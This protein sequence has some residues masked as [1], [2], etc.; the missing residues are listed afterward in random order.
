MKNC[1]SCGMIMKVHKDY[2]TDGVG[3]G[4]FRYC[5]HC[6]QGG[7]FM[8]WCKDMT[9]ADMIEYVAHLLLATGEAKTEEQ[10]RA[11]ATRR[12]LEL[13]RWKKS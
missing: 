12:C 1:Q 4:N 10:A 6:M 8:D 5:C 7:R 2:G 11:S 3:G 9:L 13:K